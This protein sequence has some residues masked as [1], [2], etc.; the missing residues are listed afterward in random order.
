MLAELQ[1]LEKKPQEASAT[2]KRVRQARRHELWRV[3]HP[4]DE[5]VAVRII[6]WFPDDSTVV[7][8]VVGFDKAGAATSGTAVLPPVVRR[9]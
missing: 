8:A 6:C 5:R 4:F 9:S 1:D 7:V 2:Y 3:G